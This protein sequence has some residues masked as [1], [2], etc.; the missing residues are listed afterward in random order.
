MFNRIA[1]GWQRCIDVLTIYISREFLIFVIFAGVAAL[2]NLIVG[3][4]LYTLAPFKTLLPYWLAVGIGAF[5]GLVVNF[6]L[7]ARYNFKAQSR[8]RLQQ[9]RTFCVIAGIGI[10]LTVGLSS[11]LLVLFRR[12]AFDAALHR[13]G[14]NVSLEFASHFLAVGLV[15]FFSFAGHKFFTFGG[16]LRVKVRVFLRARDPRPRGQEVEA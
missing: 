15:G 5:S 8:N 7:N 16:G 4:G 6:G 12:I 3:S 9:F 1:H 13:V 14:L 10:V 2:T 11:D